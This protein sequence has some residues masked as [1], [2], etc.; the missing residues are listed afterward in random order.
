MSPSRGRHGQPDAPDVLTAQGLA[1][2]GLHL[3]APERPER[4]PFAWECRRGVNPARSRR[5]FQTWT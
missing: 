5:L 2:G 3:V 1:H 4:L